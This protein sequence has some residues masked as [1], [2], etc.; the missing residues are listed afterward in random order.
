LED[1]GHFE[2]ELVG[3]GSEGKIEW[4]VTAETFEESGGK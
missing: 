1:V 2:R 3:F 4:G